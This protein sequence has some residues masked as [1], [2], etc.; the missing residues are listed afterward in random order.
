MTYYL[1]KVGR[2]GARLVSSCKD[3]Y[4]DVNAAY[5]TGAVDIIVVKQEDGS[6]KSS[7][8]HVR[9]GKLGVLRTG[10]WK[11]VCK[12]RRPDRVLILVEETKGVGG[13]GW[14]WIHCDTT[15]T[16]I[17][18]LAIH[19][20]QRNPRSASN[21]RRAVRVSILFQIYCDSTRTTIDIHVI[22]YTSTLSGS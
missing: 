12:A 5:L 16:T 13:D 21:N 17:D 10:D 11:E 1:G 6:L 19:N 4:Y 20:V 9:F 2:A 22:V 18:I 8:F 14:S 3:L 7:P 15:R